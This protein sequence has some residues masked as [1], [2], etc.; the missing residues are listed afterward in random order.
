MKKSA[1]R[2]PKLNCNDGVERGGERAQNVVVFSSHRCLQCIPPFLSEL[3]CNPK[4]S[5]HREV[6]RRQTP[7]VGRNSDSFSPL[8]VRPGRQKHDRSGANCGSWGASKF[9]NHARQLAGGSG[10]KQR[11]DHSGLTNP[12]AVPPPVKPAPVHRPH[13]QERRQSASGCQHWH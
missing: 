1:E 11:A 4:N 12:S 9:Q 13:K 2:L 5:L 6:V 8:E 10:S 7:Q 3:R